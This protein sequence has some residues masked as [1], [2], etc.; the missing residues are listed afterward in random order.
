MGAPAMPIAQARR[1]Y[2]TF[3]QLPD[4]VERLKALEQKVE[5]L[6]TEDQV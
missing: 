5:E 1:V 3:T 4:L 2:T 6:S